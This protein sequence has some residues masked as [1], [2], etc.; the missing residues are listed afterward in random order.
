MYGTEERVET[1]MK[2]A[3]YSFSYTS[4]NYGQLKGEER[5]H[6]EKWSLYEKAAIDFIKNG[7]K[8]ME[9]KTV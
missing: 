5:K 8:D 2:E 4:S 3:G 6:A 9:E 1:A 7:F